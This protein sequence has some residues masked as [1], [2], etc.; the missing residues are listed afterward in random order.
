M[1]GAEKIAEWFD[2]IHREN[3]LR[4][5]TSMS[6]WVDGYY[7]PNKGDD[8][9]WKLYGAAVT[10]GVGDALLDFTQSLGCGLTDLTRVG[11]GI[12]SEK[13]TLWGVAQDGL[14][15]ITLVGGALKIARVA[16]PYVRLG[17]ETA[18]TVS[19]SAKAAVL[20][21]NRLR[22]AVAYE[23]LEQALGGPAAVAN[24]TGT[25]TPLALLGRLAA[26]GVKTE[27][28]AVTSVDAVNALIR[29]GRGPVIFGAN[30]NNGGG[31]TLVG[32]LD[33]LGRIRYTDQVGRVIADLAQLGRGVKGVKS[34]FPEAAI[35]LDSTML[36][37]FRAGAAAQVLA[38]NAYPID[39]ARMQAIEN[40]ARQASGRP[41][42]MSVTPPP[43]AA[44]PPKPNRA[45]TSG[46]S[47]VLY[48]DGKLIC[49]TTRQYRVVVGDNLGKIAGRFY[50][51]AQQWMRIYEANK[52]TLGPNPQRPHLLPGQVLLVP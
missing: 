37:F 21:G 43:P 40:A 36:D 42:P 31:H 16:A 19:S 20:S 46:T 2:E 1:W 51:N 14:R 44:T 49:T 35:A 34:V 33:L 25:A 30:L 52:Q 22:V 18:C 17:G 15:I 28:V 47:C 50:G 41:A 27:R 39:P 12:F 8:Q 48:G 3:M 13:R 23:G 29:Q 26:M 9:S 24:S 38:G 6:A 4:Y 10:A 32:F 11:D 7:N 5:R 45:P